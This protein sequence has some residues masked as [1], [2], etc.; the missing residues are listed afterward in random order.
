[1]PDRSSDN[2]ALPGATASTMQPARVGQATVPAQPSGR[3]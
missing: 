1:M 3:R 2:H